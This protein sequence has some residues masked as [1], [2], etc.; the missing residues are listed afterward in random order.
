M[1]N[2][3]LYSLIISIFSIC[4][5]TNE[6]YLK[7]DSSQKDAIYFD[8][9]T[10]TDSMF[11]NFGFLPIKDSTFQVKIKMSGIPRDYDRVIKVKMV[12]ERHASG[13]FI[14]A[15]SSYYQIPETIVMLKD[16]VVARL[17]IKL[18]RD[19]ELETVR[20]ILTV[21]LEENDNFD[22]RGHREYTI[23][24]DDK[25]PKMPAW[26]EMSIYRLGDFTKVKYQ[27]FLGYFWDMETTQPYFYNKIV[28]TWGRELNLQSNKY[29]NPYNDYPI[30]MDKYVTQRLYDYQQAN[31]GVISGV[32][33]PSL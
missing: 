24:F 1:K 33:D 27:L 8:F 9:T 6:D 21:E 10:E 7:Y 14:A 32:V 30:A 13:E 29:S 11:Y 20:A 15:K 19:K 28:A 22:I 31:P 17:P 23:T 18:I 3:L 5:C 26:W 4:S 2:I 25:M 12:N 16:S